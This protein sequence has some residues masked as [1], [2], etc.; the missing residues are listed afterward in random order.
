MAAR[1]KK[2][3]K[4]DYELLPVDELEEIK[5]KL[6]KYS[7]SKSSPLA[8]DV[9]DLKQNMSRLSDQIN[10]MS[11]IFDAAHEEV[12]IEKRQDEFVEE[13]MKP[14]K[15]QVD[16]VARQNKIIASAILNLSEHVDQEFKDIKNM[17]MGMKHKEPVPMAK[18][19]PMQQQIHQPMMQQ[20]MRQ[21]MPQPKPSMPAKKPEEKKK[22]M[23][24][25]LFK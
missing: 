21:A 20:P 6:E 11:E 5:K 24:S 25:D 4:K 10:L 22:G 1:K 16:E 9:D 7:H 15:S 14:L 3:V 13:I 2:S 19:Y 23:F 8:E 18:Q 17:L 12:E